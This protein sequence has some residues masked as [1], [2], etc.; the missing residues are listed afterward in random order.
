MKSGKPDI[1]KKTVSKFDLEH[2]LRMIFH[3]SCPTVILSVSEESA[4]LLLFGDTKI[5]LALR[6]TYGEPGNL[7]GDRITYRKVG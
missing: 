4:H 2:Q 5:F 3:Y 1:C 7:L 6:M